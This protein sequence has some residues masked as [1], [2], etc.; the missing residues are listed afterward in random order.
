MQ[1]SPVISLSL[2]YLSPLERGIDGKLRLTS[3]SNNKSLSS[4]LGLALG[5]SVLLIVLSIV[6]GFEREMRER[7][8]A[9]V[10]H[11]VLH[12]YEGVKDWESIA[13]EIEAIGSDHIKPLAIAPLVSFQALL[14][15]EDKTAAIDINGILPKAENRVS[16][17]DSLMVSGKLNALEEKPFGIVLGS[18]LAEKLN[19]T[20]GDTIKLMLPEAKI[21]LL[22]VLPRYR[23]FEVVGIFKVGA[24]LDAQLA[25]IHIETAGKMIRNKGK[26]ASVRLLMPNLF[27]AAWDGWELAQYLNRKSIESGGEEVWISADWTQTQGTLYEI[28]TMTKS[29]LGLLVLLIVLVACF[30]LASSLIMLVNDKRSDIAILLSQGMSSKEVTFVFI[31]QA[32]LIACM[33]LTIGFSMAIILLSFLGDW[34]LAL[35]LLLE[36]DLTSAYP[37]HYLPSEILLQDVVLISLSVFILTLISSLYPAIQAAKVNPAEELKYE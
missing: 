35:E 11:V 33:G 12:H 10:P 14:V 20:Q 13:R 4:I 29:M 16:I 25:Y 2:R 18:Q 17:V 31:F 8:L 1:N 28:I 21:S 5:T 6:N 26:V 7:I 9:V 3:I 30:N 32:F 36:V 22:G 34:I 19:V 23:Q 24:I 37:V 27:N 15:S